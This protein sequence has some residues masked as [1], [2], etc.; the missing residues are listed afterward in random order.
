M[1]RI[2]IS[3]FKKTQHFS[4][5]L[6]L[7]F[8]FSL[9]AGILLELLNVY[10]C[11]TIYC[12]YTKCRIVINTLSRLEKWPSDVVCEWDICSITLQTHAENLPAY[13]LIAHRNIYKNPLL[14]HLKLSQGK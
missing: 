14:F 8:F 12:M 5:E 1:L 13:P 4:L 3:T 10:L 6:T 7:T 9:A 11:S 2:A